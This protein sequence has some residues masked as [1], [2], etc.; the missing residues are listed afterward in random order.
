MKG[1]IEM[2]IFAVLVWLGT[3]AFMLYLPNVI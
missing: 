3:S 1:F 2:L